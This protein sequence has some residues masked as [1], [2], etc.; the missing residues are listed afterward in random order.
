MPY[1]L[2]GFARRTIRMIVNIA[3]PYLITLTMLV[4]GSLAGFPPPVEAAD[5]PA[6]WTSSYYRDHSLA[7]KIWQPRAGRF[8]ARGLLIGELAKSRFVLLGEKHDNPDHHRLQA[9][10]VRDLV[11]KGQKWAVAFEMLDEGQKAGIVRHH[12]THPKDAGP[13]GDAVGWSKT[14]WPEWANYRPIAQMALDM[15]APIVPA[16]LQRV[17]LRR[18]AR[19]GI[20]ILGSARISRLGLDRLPGAGILANIRRELVE[21]HCGL[22]PETMIEPMVKVAVAKDAVMARALLDA[23]GQG[24][25]NGAVLIAG[26]G[27]VRT[28]RGVPWHI[29]RL[30]PSESV[31]SVAFIE[32]EK[33][34]NDRAGY[35]TIF[36]ADRLPFDFVWF[37]PRVDLDDP[38]SK[39]AP[40]LKR[41]GQGKMPEK[42]AP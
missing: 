7:G 5:A 6:E 25:G 12:A 24:A 40:Q 4:S 42:K 1:V 3:T 13:L 27:H 16:S 39:F 20:A 31:Q 2:Q 28:D 29:R 41:A 37:T 8:V 21:T 30:A 14:G 26:A 38:C 34:R 17:T 35:A 36:D 32:V 11:G 33:D 18:I 10:I 15:G 9:L 22:L 19:E 23:A